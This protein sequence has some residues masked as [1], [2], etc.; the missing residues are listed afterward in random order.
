MSTTDIAGALSGHILAAMDTLLYILI[1][2]VV[3]GLAIYLAQL[4]VPV[5]A[6][7]YVQSIFGVL[8]LLWLL[9]YA[10]HGFGHG[11]VLP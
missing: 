6:R 11:A 8:V 9:R 2:S 1:V 7:V 10:L 5:G 3:A 4:F